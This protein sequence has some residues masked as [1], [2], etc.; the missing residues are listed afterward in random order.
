MSPQ[1]V[2][3]Q[4]KDAIIKRRAEAVLNFA[5]SKSKNKSPNIKR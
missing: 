4:R 5:K 2:Y 3:Q 1:L